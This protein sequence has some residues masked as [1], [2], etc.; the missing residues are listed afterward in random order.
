MGK[1]VFISVYRRILY[2]RICIY[3]E[4][5]KSTV[6]KT[7]PDALIVRIHSQAAHRMHDY[8]RYRLQRDTQ[9]R[10]HQPEGGHL[11]RFCT[12]LAP[13]IVRTARIY[14]YKRWAR[15]YFHPSI[16][17]A[18]NTIVTRR[19]NNFVVWRDS[20]LRLI[21][22]DAMPHLSPHCSSLPFVRR[23]TFHSEFSWL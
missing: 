18:H 21:S 8:Q 13:S 17:A 22:C 14:T 3:F 12:S 9:G 7:K 15:A 2:I 19:T 6:W 16:C 20:W 11:V 23:P 10:A 4:G 5:S 1:N